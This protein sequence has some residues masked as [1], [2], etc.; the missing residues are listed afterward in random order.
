MAAYKLL[1]CTFLPCLCSLESLISLGQHLPSFLLR[2]L[3]VATVKIR[4]LCWRLACGGNFSELD[5]MWAARSNTLALAPDS[6]CAPNQIMLLHRCSSHCGARLALFLR[7]FCLGTCQQA[8]AVPEKQCR[9][10]QD[11]SS[12]S[13]RRSSKTHTKFFSSKISLKCSRHQFRQQVHIYKSI[14][15]YVRKLANTSRQQIINKFASTK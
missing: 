13:A 10:D 11:M 9:P 5:Q 14:E 1:V 8:F 2:N 6:S 12:T 3:T 4:S 7:P 15:K